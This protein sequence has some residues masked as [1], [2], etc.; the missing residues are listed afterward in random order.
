MFKTVTGK[1]A[2]KAFLL[3]FSVRDRHSGVVFCATTYGSIR[4]CD[5]KAQ[6]KRRFFDCFS[7]EMISYVTDL[8]FAV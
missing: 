3:S 8:L 1:T 4:F 5:I 2:I 7:S 6:K